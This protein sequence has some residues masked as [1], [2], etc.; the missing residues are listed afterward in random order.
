MIVD[1][2]D[3]TGALELLMGSIMRRNGKALASY[4]EENLLACLGFEASH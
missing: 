3:A 1:V 2:L 4:V